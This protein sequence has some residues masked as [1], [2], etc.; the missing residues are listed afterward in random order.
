MSIVGAI[1]LASEKLMDAGWS[2]NHRL[3]LVAVLMNLA[4]VFFSST[5]LAG[6]ASEYA[7]HFYTSLLGRFPAGAGPHLLAE[8]AVHFTLFFSLGFWL[9]ECLGGHRAERFWKAAVLCLVVGLLSEML[10]S[11]FPGRHPS[12]ADIMLNGISATLAAALAA[13]SLP[14]L[15][16]EA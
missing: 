10:Q 8:K 2:F 4:L 6:E 9:Y 16:R 11:L 13:C 14:P 5:G 15:V 3:R 7:F 12:L 1:E